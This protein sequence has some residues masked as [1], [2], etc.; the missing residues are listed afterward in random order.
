MIEAK[1]EDLIGDPC[2]SDPLDKK[3]RND[4]IE[5]ISPHCTN[6]TRPSSAENITPQVSARLPHHP[7]ADDFEIGS[8]CQGSVKHAY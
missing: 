3:L 6:R 2:G 1:P 4:G 5:M 7:S 8:K